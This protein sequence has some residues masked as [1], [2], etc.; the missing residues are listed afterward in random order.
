[1]SIAS[2]VLSGLFTALL[3]L[4]FIG[5]GVWAWSARRKESFEQAAR[6]PLEEDQGE[7]P[8]THRRQQS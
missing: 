6:L 7:A 2:G 3:I 4:V 8:V 1:M 5:I